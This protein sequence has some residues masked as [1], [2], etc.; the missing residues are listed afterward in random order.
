MRG[1]TVGVSRRV[2]LIGATGSIRRASDRGRA[3]RARARRYRLRLDS[4]RQARATDRSAA[5]SRELLD[6]AG[7]RRA[8][9][10]GRLRRPAG[11]SGHSSTG[12][13]SRLRTRE[14][15][16]AA[17]DLALAARE[18]GGRLLPVDSEHSAAFQCLDG[19]AP[20]QVD[21]LVPT[22]SGGLQG[23]RVTDSG[24]HGGRG[25]CAPTWNMGPGSRQTP[26]H[27]Q[28]GARADRGSFLFGLPTSGSRWSCTRV[29]RARARALPRRRCAR[30]P[31][32]SGHARA[33]LVR[34]DLSGPLGHT[35]PVARPR[36]GNDARV[37]RPRPG[38]VPSSPPRPGGRRARRNLPVRL[39][40][41]NGWL[42]RPS[43]RDDC[44]SSGRG[45]SEETLAA[46]G[47]TPA[48]DLAD[49][50]EADAEARRLTERRAAVA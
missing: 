34:T 42:S 25:A 37:S 9:R 40:R 31:G 6:R 48:R 32:L 35:R 7:R 8:G 30:P 14:A 22:A 49:L 28:Q 38:D 5:I 43:S 21:S 16:V 29:G 23:R 26:P 10:G 1:H 15:C 45:D 18:G 13:T 3:S 19:W 12:S 24:R 17:G 11:N 2:A 4:G 46:V 36:V 41:P 47:G 50:V 27:R 39:Q 33:D 44:P 20:E